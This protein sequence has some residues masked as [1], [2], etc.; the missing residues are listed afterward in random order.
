[1]FS[2]IIDV[3]GKQLNTTVVANIP[4][5]HHGKDFVLE[6]ISDGSI[7]I[8]QIE[9]DPIITKFMPGYDM[10]YLVRSNTSKK[11]KIGHTTDLKSRMST[12]R[13]NNPEILSVISLS[14]GGKPFEEDLKKKYAEFNI[15]GEWFFLED[16]QVT[17]I[18]LAMLERR[19][20]MIDKPVSVKDS[21]PC[22]S[23][24]SPVTSSSVSSSVSEITKVSSM[25]PIVGGGIS[26]LIRFGSNNSSDAAKTSKRVT[27]GCPITRIGETRPAP[28]FDFSKS[29]N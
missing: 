12:M 7:V 25:S 24:S 8:K 18:K 9:I 14:P 10:T 28:R 20:L 13:S 17:N 1:M 21:T 29:F 2:A 16:Y 4:I 6:K 27:I 22:S 23:V 5:E 26:S 11:Y 19:K 3:D 15:T